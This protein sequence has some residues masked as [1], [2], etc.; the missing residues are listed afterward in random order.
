MDWKKIDLIIVFGTAGMLLLAFAII[1]FVIA[2]QRR[3]YTKQRE[4]KELE[5]ETQKQLMEAVI[6]TKEKEQK[7]IA[8]ELHDGI[9]SALT[10]LKVSLIQMDLLAEDKKWIGDSIKSIGND[11]RR[12]SNELMPSILEDMGLQ[13]AMRKLVEMLERSSKI[14][15]NLVQQS[16]LSQHI[17]SDQEELAIYRVIQEILNNI[18]KYANAS[19]VLVVEKIEQNHYVLEIIDNGDGFSPSENDL[20]KSGSLGLKNIKSRIQQVNGSIE[21][22]KLVSGGTKVIIQTPYYEQY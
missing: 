1:I 20:T 6:L 4:L 13:M 17:H 2:Y 16:E 11:V 15:F 19:E 5:L 14:K 7:R 22:N 18:V 10:A 21:Y 12:I 8:Q 3:L 9:G